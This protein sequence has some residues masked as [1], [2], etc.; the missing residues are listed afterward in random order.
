MQPFDHDGDV[1][2][3]FIGMRNGGS[4]AA[5]GL[6]FEVSLGRQPAAVDVLDA[7]LGLAGSGGGCRL[8]EAAAS[9]TI[10]SINQSDDPI[11]SP[12]RPASLFDQL[13]LYRFNLHLDQFILD[14]SSPSVLLFLAS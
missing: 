14:R 13:E 8:T 11:E 12:C 4:A 2:Q 3:S 10:V 1:V 5:G 9:A 7:G 6:T